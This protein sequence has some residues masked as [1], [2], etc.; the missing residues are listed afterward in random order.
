MPLI[1]ASGISDAQRQAIGALTH[2]AG[3][4]VKMNYTASGSGTDTLLT[5]DALL[6]TFM[7]SNAK[8]GY[9]SGSNL[10][11]T[12]R[13]N[14]VNPNLDAG[15]P[16]LFGIT[17][18]GGHAI[19]CDGYGYN[20]GTEYHHLNMGWAGQDDAWYNLPAIT[21]TSYNF[22]SVYKCVYNIF[23]TG[24]GEIVSGRALDQSSNPVSE[25]TVTATRNGGGTYTATTNSRGIYALAKVPS[26]SMYSVTA[27]KTGYTFETHSVNTGTSINNSPTTG[28][29]EGSRY[30]GKFGTRSQYYF[31][32][33]P[34]Q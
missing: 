15:F 7:Y 6:N 17:G 27:A 22:T 8:K 31:K 34:G 10:P 18:D 29:L 21:T 11:T 26:D 28:N 24:S 13:D 33:R 5:G 4:A 25:A 1:P 2:D 12:Q 30:S 16:V 19:D 20:I 9:N 14:M 32:Y 23:V 3:V